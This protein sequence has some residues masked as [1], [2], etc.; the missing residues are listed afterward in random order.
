MFLAKEKNT[1]NCV[2]AKSLKTLDKKE[3]GCGEI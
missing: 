1:S 2:I 3:W